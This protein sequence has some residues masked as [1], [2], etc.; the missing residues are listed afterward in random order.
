[1]RDFRVDFFRIFEI[2]QFADHLALDL[3]IRF[4]P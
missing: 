4:R 1:M 2:C 3:V